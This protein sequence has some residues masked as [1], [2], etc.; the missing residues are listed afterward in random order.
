LISRHFPTP[1]PRRVSPL[2]LPPWGLACIVASKCMMRSCSTLDGAVP[3]RGPRA[4]VKGSQLN[5]PGKVDVIDAIPRR[6]SRVHKNGQPR[7]AS[8]VQAMENEDALARESQAGHENKAVGE[9]VVELYR[10]HWRVTCSD[11]R[12]LPFAVYPLRGMRTHTSSGWQCCLQ[13][14]S[15]GLAQQPLSAKYCALSR[16]AVRPCPNGWW[17]RRGTSHAGAWYRG[18]RDPG[19]PQPACGPA[20]GKGQWDDGGACCS[21][22]ARRDKAEAHS[23]VKQLGGGGLGQGRRVS[24]AGQHMEHQRSN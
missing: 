20:G 10:D 3:G 4:W 9:G 17:A 13:G 15:S 8:Q 14:A 5:W 23:D 18:A 22:R 16:K 11:D 21:R 7:Q 12:G 2:L 6:W 24:L 19:Q 1:L